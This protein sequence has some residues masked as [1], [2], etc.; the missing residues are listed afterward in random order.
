MHQ[1]DRGTNLRRGRQSGDG[2]ILRRAWPVP[3][4]HLQRHRALPQDGGVELRRQPGPVESPGRRRHGLSGR[5][6]AVRH[7]HLAYRARQCRPH[8]SLQPDVPGMLRQRQRGG[9]SLRAEHRAG[10]HHAGHAARRAAGGWPRGAVLR[11]RAHGPS[12]VLRDSLDGARHGIHPHPGRD[13]RHRAGRL[14]S[15]R[16]KPKRQDWRRSICNST[17]WTTTS[18]AACAGRPC[19]RPR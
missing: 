18:I 14:W 10:S 16:R 5:L 19:S 3:R 13:Q 11:R 8:Q 9:L 12:A 6:R 15:S 2:E 4:H 7:A 1:G 17:A